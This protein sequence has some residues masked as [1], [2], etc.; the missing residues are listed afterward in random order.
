MINIQPEIIERQSQDYVAIAASVAMKDIPTVLPQLIPRVLEWTA[1][2]NEQAGPVFFRYLRMTGDSI[3]VEVGVPTRSQL[4]GDGDIRPGKIPAGRY[5]AATYIGPY[6]NLP[7]VHAAI[8]QWAHEQ[9]VKARGTRLEFYS[10]GPDTEPD[11][12][13]WQT[14]VIV[15]VVD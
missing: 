2:K 7:Q 12:A 14:E 15:Q 3:D 1:K 8:E 6:L 10:N 11:P 5:V 4:Q 13:K 9:G